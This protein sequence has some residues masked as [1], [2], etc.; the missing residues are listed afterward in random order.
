[1]FHPSPAWR[2]GGGKKVAENENM[3]KNEMQSEAINTMTSLL[4]I[5]VKESSNYILFYFSF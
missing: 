1:M 4:S 3:S 2:L 5:Y